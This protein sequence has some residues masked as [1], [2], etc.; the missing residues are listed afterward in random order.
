M[1]KLWRRTGLVLGL[2]AFGALP[3]YANNPPRPDGLLSLIL[4]FPV[5]ILGFH[6]AGAAYTDKQRKWRLVRGFFLGVAVLFTAGGT[7]IALIPLV[8]LLAYG[9]QRGAQIIQRGQGKK[10]VLI[11]S[12]VLLW[13][14]FAV[15]DYMIS[16]N[17][18][19]RFYAYESSAVGGMRALQTAETTFK[20][21]PGPDRT[22]LNLYGSLEDLRKAQ[23]IDD[24]FLNHRTRYGYRYSLILEPSRQQFLAYAVPEEYLPRTTQWRAFVPGGSWVDA[25][26][27]RRGATRSFAVDETGII[28]AADLGASRPVTRQ[29][30]QKWPPLN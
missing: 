13:V 28:R 5:A 25:L 22:P 30:A 24:I 9:V 4:I 20:Q 15:G 8:I 7:E 27:P 18:S 21:S 11:G 16:L 17:V 3:A 6:L 19:T 12:L 26:R 10:R 29:E 1:K 23:L 2:V 14:L